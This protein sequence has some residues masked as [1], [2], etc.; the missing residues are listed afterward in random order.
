MSWVIPERAELRSSRLRRAR[1]PGRR[2]SPA[3]SM[4][5]ARARIG[6]RR[7]SSSSGTIGAASTIP[8]HRRCRAT[9]KAVPDSASR[10]SSSHPTCRSASGSQG[11][12]VSHTVY[13][14]GSIIRFI[15]DTWNL[16]RLGTTDSTCTSMADM[17]EPRASRRA[18]S[19]RF[20]R[21]SRES[22]FLHQ[23]PSDLPVDTE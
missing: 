17:F 21:A 7:R 11:G 2:G 9:I 12:Y 1:T 8:S 10:C 15:E 22:Y 20:P 19:S 14:F 5:S 23:K 16:G 3:S 6:T 13:G 4:R 18:R